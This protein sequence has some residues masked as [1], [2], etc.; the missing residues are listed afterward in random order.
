MFLPF[1]IICYDS[2]LWKIASSVRLL[3]ALSIS[4]VRMWPRGCAKNL[5]DEFSETSYREITTFLGRIF[6]S[7][8]EFL[9]SRPSCQPWVPCSSGT[10]FAKQRLASADF[11]DDNFLSQ[12]T[13]VWSWDSYLKPLLLSHGCTLNLCCFLMVVLCLISPN[14]ATCSVTLHK[15]VVSVVVKR[16][17]TFASLAL[18]TL[19]PMFSFSIRVVGLKLRFGG[20][21]FWINQFSEFFCLLF[22]WIGSN[23]LIFCAALLKWVFIGWTLKNGPFWHVY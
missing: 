13:F 9:H 2:H 10:A 12:L 3:I 11:W 4:W 14:F 5:L 16:L 23:R 20:F 21:M 15:H 19:A 8:F 1:A 7:R 6:V 17:S 18:S 22:G